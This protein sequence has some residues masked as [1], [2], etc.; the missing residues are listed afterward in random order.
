MR[1]GATDYLISRSPS[2]NS[3]RSWIAPRKRVRP[4]LPRN[5]CVSAC[6]KPHDLGSRIG[7]STE[8]EKL[9]RILSKVAQTAHPSVALGESG[10]AK[11]W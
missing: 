2:T 8:M 11:S 7:R 4:M 1:G 10:T 6:G 5:C 3:R 9:Y